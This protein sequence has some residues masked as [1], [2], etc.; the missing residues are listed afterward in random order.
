MIIHRPSDFAASAGR[1]I[2]TVVPSLLLLSGTAAAESKLEKAG[3]FLERN[4]TD[5][6][7]EVRFIASG[8]EKGL[9]SLRVTAPDGRTVIDFKSPSSKSGIRKLD[10]ESPEPPLN[11]GRIQAD[12]PEGVYRFEAQEVEG[13][14]LRGESTLSH[15]LPEAPAIRQPSEGEEVPLLNGKVR[16]EAVKD[17]TYIVVVQEKGKARELRLTLP[18]GK[19]TLSIPSGFLVAGSKYKVEVG[20]V[21]KNGNR[22]FV[23][24]EFVAAAAR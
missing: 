9:A 14:V 6:D 18:E 5:D 1:I 24:S 13:E 4:Q 23:E 2:A 22:T 3:I 15:K 16:W 11:D 8:N 19:T 10:L 20:A 12:F 7:I 21:W 17:A